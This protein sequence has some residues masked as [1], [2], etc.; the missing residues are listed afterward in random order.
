MSVFRRRTVRQMDPLL[1]PSA[2]ESPCDAKQ[3]SHG[4]YWADC[5]ACYVACAQISGSRF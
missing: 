3:E 2:P 1:A 5:N 4:D